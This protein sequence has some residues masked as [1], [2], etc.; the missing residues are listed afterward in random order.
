[1]TVFSPA[2]WEAAGSRAAYT[3]LAALIPLIALV[4]S[5]DTTPLDALLVGATYVLA[6]FATS[7]AGLPEVQGKTVPLL[8]AVLV[9]T[10]KTLGQGIATALVGV[11]LLTAVNWT[12]AA[13]LVG[14]AVLVTLLRTLQEYLPEQQVTSIPDA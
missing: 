2:W 9:R 5:Q 14:S 11:E 13:V 7:L 6:S 10:A 8:R 3:G 4:A 1:M 12:E